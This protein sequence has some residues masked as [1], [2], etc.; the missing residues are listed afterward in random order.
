M[1]F[2]GEAFYPIIK[3][4]IDLTRLAKGVSAPE[5]WQKPKTVYIEPLKGKA[6]IQ[7]MTDIVTGGEIKGE[8]YQTERYKLISLQMD[9][10]YR[11]AIINNAIQY[12]SIRNSINWNKRVNEFIQARKGAFENYLFYPVE[13]DLYSGLIVFGKKDFQFKGLINAD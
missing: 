4:E 2:Q 9:S 10:E 3:D 12:A 5:I 11:R 6:A 1:V 13:T 7:R 8:M